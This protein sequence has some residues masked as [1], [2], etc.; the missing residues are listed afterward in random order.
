MIK[1]GG[2]SSTTSLSSATEKETL[3]KKRVR[4]VLLQC[5]NLLAFSI[6]NNLKPT[7]M[8]LLQ[9]VGLSITQ[10]GKVTWRFPDV[11]GLSIEK[12]L[13]PKIQ[14]LTKSLNITNDISSGDLANLAVRYPRILGFN[15]IQNFPEKIN[16]FMNELHFTV[17]ELRA[18]FIKRPQILSL[19]I[20]SNIQPN[21]CYYKDER[22]HI[23][24]PMPCKLH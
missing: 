6:D 9:D 7:I 19:N 12:N 3:I 18:L 21:T 10:V 13:R 20:S 24:Q 15:M 22:S 11:L 23:T 14:Y 5:P 4:T 17:D 16:F 1:R 8:F 2:D